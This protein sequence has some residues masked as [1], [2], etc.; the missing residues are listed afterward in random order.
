MNA[1]LAGVGV[2]WNWAGGW[3]QKVTPAMLARGA[4]VSTALAAVAEAARRRIAEIPEDPDNGAGG[5]C[6]TAPT[7]N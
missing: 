4:A 2:E 1:S 5:D 7:D 3:R 6:T